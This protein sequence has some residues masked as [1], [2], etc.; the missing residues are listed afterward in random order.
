MQK[1]SHRSGVVRK[2]PIVPQ[3]AK[4]TPKKAEVIDEKPVEMPMPMHRE[5]FVEKSAS[6][7]TGEIVVKYPTEIRLSSRPRGPLRNNVVID[8]TL[9]RAYVRV[10]DVNPVT[11]SFS[12]EENGT[13][14]R[15]LL[16]NYYRVTYTVYPEGGCPMARFPMQ[17]DKLSVGQNVEI[18]E[19]K[20]EN[21]I[22]FEGV[23]PI[24]TRLRVFTDSRLLRYMVNFELIGI[25]GISDLSQTINRVTQA[26]ID[27]KVRYITAR[28]TNI[29]VLPT[30]PEIKFY[31]APLTL[32][33]SPFSPSDPNNTN[34]NPLLPDQTPSG[35]Q[36]PWV[37]AVIPHKKNQEF[38]EGPGVKILPT[39]QRAAGEIPA[40]YNDAYG[41][42]RSVTNSVNAY[43]GFE[44][45]IV[46]PKNEKWT[47]FL[48]DLKDRGRSD[49]KPGSPEEEWEIINYQKKA[50]M[51][52]L[53]ID[54]LQFYLPKIEQFVNN[55]FAAVSV[56]DHSFV[57]SF[58]KNLVLF[59]LRMHVGN[60]DYP[61]Y[62]IQWF[63]DFITFI[64][65]G[66]PNSL[67]RSQLLQYGAANSPRIFE[68][69]EKR[70]VKAV[71][72]SD[73]STLTYWWSQAG[74]SAQALVFECVHNIVA[75]SQFTH[76]IFQMVYATLP[77]ES[78]PP[79]GIVPTP[80]NQFSFRRDD[81]NT[82]LCEIADGVVPGWP[83][84]G[85][86]KTPIP[87]AQNPV[88]AD[89]RP[90]PNFFELYRNATTSQAK[91]NVIRE[92][93]RILS[94]NALSF[95]LLNPGNPDIDPQPVVKPRHQH[96]QI[97][98][99]ATGISVS[100]GSYPGQAPPGTGGS[101][102]AIYFSYNPSI[103]DAYS[104]P[105]DTLDNLEEIPV[106]TDVLQASA[107]TVYDK[108]TVVDTSTTQSRNLIPL[109][110]RPIYAPFGLGYRRCAGEMFSYLVTQYILEKFSTV[111]FELRG[112]WN[113][114]SL[115]SVAPFKQVRDNIYVVQTKY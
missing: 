26:D 64:G 80:P 74:L 44:Q 23:F 81:Y 70:N 104:G 78:V 52:A 83:F 38:P 79:A 60:D 91:M 29:T 18:I 33:G 36:F 46:K 102:T 112:K 98:I 105:N 24:D 17:L 101:A 42:F 39:P 55:A 43:I 40:H 25:V 3:Y 37:E 77:S 90:F 71:T 15:F 69:F 56:Y 59:F 97:M 93:Y 113:E 5:T 85:H 41:K 63:S 95:S 12:L 107:T 100:E 86:N 8:E 75:F 10:Q 14:I 89:R 48:T 1:L 108:E 62:V 45:T 27:T 9:A 54:K 65:I 6:D 106:V 7:S 32:P 57:S 76:V 16:T 2:S 4:V 99:A 67:E 66:N 31:S 84:A 111:K 21:S 28:S 53:S 88:T 61:D 115:I 51:F 49:P 72:E 110:P 68:Y 94:P 96:Q 11:N 82:Q 19:S 34:F 35:A 87:A 114:G 50:Y 73:V 30:T 92:A 47:V 109:F 58:Q 103:Y 20:T 13:V 22:T